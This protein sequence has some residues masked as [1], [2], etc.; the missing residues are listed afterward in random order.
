[1]FSVL[2][3]LGFSVGNV[4][5][6]RE[7]TQDELRHVFDAVDTNHSGTLDFEELCACFDHLG[8]SESRASIARLMNEIDTDGDGAVGFEEFVAAFQLAETGEDVSRL[9]VISDVAHSL[10]L[11]EDELVSLR[12]VFDTHDTSGTGDLDQQ[13][14]TNLLKSF[15]LYESPRATVQLITSIDIDGMS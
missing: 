11:S 6:K 10:A 12:E 14:L 3:F 7:L 2:R 15:E 5:Q 1:M 8:M 4:P 9:S 13:G